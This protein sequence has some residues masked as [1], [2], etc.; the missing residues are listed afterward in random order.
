[1]AKKLNGYFTAMLDAKK[2]GSESFVYNGKTYIK[3]MSK[4]GLAVYK[5]K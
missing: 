4:T 3:K 5:A 2:K 1:M